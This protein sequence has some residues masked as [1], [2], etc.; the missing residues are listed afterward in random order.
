MDTIKVKM[1]IIIAILI[2]FILTISLF[3]YLI[4]NHKKEKYRKAG[5]EWDEIVK[6]LRRRKYN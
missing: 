6:E 2:L 4:Y 3:N 5:K 1:G